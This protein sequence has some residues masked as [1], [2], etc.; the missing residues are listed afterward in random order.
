MAKK[1]KCKTCGR[2]FAAKTGER[3]CSELCKTAGLFIGGGGDTTKPR[4]TSSGRPVIPE[5]K[6]EETPP[7]KPR[8]DSEKMVRVRQ[9]FALPVE[10]RWEIAQHFTKEEQDY[11]RRIAK[12]MIAEDARIES[13][14]AW[15][16]DEVNALRE[17]G[18]LGDSDDGS[19]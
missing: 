1:R 19:I 4:Q 2:P 9:M 12:R 8:H 11:A 13:E 3:Y 6:S 14:W 7:P 15:E 18:F 17:S 5:K 16:S 10:K